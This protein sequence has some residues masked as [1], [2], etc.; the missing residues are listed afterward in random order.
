MTGDCGQTAGDEIRGLTKNAFAGFREPLL[1]I[2][3]WQSGN[4]IFIGN[5]IATAVI[6][7]GAVKFQSEDLAEET[8]APVITN[9]N[10]W[11]MRE[12]CDS[13]LEFFSC[14]LYTSDAAD[15]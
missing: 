7:A 11:L 5:G 13:G 6:I 1:N 3:P 15:E 8:T 12:L 2:G 10:D 9:R 14:L 4:E